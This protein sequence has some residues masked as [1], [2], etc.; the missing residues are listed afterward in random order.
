MGDR[1]WNRGFLDVRL[2]LEK[3]ELPLAGL[4]LQ[5]TARKV[6]SEFVNV[7]QSLSMFVNVCQSLSKFHKASQSLSKF[8][9][10]C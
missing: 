2:G 3:C 5:R 6:V 7:C 1:S 8:V 10:V 4:Q 9:N